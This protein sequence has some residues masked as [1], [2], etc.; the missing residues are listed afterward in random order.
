MPPTMKYRRLGNSGLL[1][2]ALSFGSGYTFAIQLGFEK[3]YAIMERAFTSGINFFDNAEVYAG[4]K[5]EELMGRIIQT[6][7]ERGLWTRE[8]LVIS[9]K[10]MIGTRSGPNFI[11]LSRKHIMEGVNA[12]LR[13]LGLDYVDLV[14]CHRPDASTPIEET[15]RGMSRLIDEGKAFYWGTSEWHSYDILQACEIADRLRLHRPIMDQAQY[16]LLERSRVELNYVDLY[17]KFNYGL[18][19]WS[20]LAAG[21]LT[22]KYNNGIP[23]GSRLSLETNLKLYAKG[24]DD[25]IAIARKLEVVALEIGITL[26]QLSIAWVLANDHVST[27]ILGAT[28]VAQLD[29]NLEAIEHVGKLTPDVKA[30]IDEIVKYVPQNLP[31]HEASVTALRSKYL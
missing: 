3:A 18:T 16:H 27:V 24:L 8:D 28:S 7:V 30:R 31:R 4:G 21:I 13:R 22:G 25:R 29:E 26:A 5:S 10:V 9:T 20:P 17:K 12:S 14:F 19:T 2:S 23:D 6:G 11:G 1:V 15:V